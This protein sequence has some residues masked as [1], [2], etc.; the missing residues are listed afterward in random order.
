MITINKKVVKLDIIKKIAELFPG[1]TVIEFLK[2]INYCE[3]IE[4]ELG[5]PIIDV[6]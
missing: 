2:Y 6:N 4:E 1:M 5:L 3:I